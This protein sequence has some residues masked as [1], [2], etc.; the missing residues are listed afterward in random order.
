MKLPSMKSAEPSD[1]MSRTVRGTSSARAIDGDTHDTH[2]LL[3]LFA[4][5]VAD[6]RPAVR[7]WQRAAR[8]CNL[9][10]VAGPC[11][12]YHGVDQVVDGGKLVGYATKHRPRIAQ[13]RRPSTLQWEWMSVVATR[14]N[15]VLCPGRHVDDGLDHNSSHPIHQCRRLVVRVES[16]YLEHGNR[17]VVALS[18]FR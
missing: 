10:I 9:D 16:Y 12:K 17:G 18:R 15:R 7:Y 4:D 2:L 6:V 5:D 11:D 1:W 14:A 8:V 3:D 13:R